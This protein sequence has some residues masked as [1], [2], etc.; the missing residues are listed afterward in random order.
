MKNLGRIKPLFI[1]L[2][3]AVGCVAAQAQLPAASSLPSKQVFSGPSLAHIS[4]QIPTREDMTAE[5]IFEQVED[6]GAV[7]ACLLLSVVA[8]RDYIETL[9]EYSLNSLANTFAYVDLHQSPCKPIIS[10]LILDTLAQAQYDE[11]SEDFWFYD[12]YAKAAT[13]LG[14]N[15]D[16][17]DS[18]LSWA[19]EQVERAAMRTNNGTEGAIWAAMVLSNMAVRHENDE[20]DIYTI[21]WPARIKFEQRLRDIIAQY[22]YLKNESADYLLPR[23]KNGGIVDKTNQTVLVQLFAQVNNFFS[24]KRAGS[25]LQV[26]W[27]TGGFN[28]MLRPQDVSSFSDATE[29]FYLHHPTPGTDGRGNWAD[30][31]NGRKH[32]ILAL[33]LQGL[34]S[35]YVTH[36]REEAAELFSS[37][38]KQ[39]IKPA[40]QGGFAHYL[41]VSL[42]MMRFGKKLLPTSAEWREEE[43]RL[44]EQLYKT[45]KRE[46]SIVP[47]M[48]TVQGGAEVGSE[49]VLF[50]GVFKVVG[51][52]VV[53]PVAKGIGKLWVK[54]MPKRTRV[55]LRRNTIERAYKLVG[56]NF[57]QS[58]HYR[59]I[60]KQIVR[61]EAE[62]AQSLT[63]ATTKAEIV[64]KRKAMYQQWVEK[65]W[66]S[67]EEMEFRIAADAEKYLGIKSPYMSGAKR[68]IN[69]IVKKELFHP[70]KKDPLAY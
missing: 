40:P 12:F 65:G 63:R 50:D 47:V 23:I 2:F 26:F 5:D 22:D 43:K 62:F 39:Y 41:F 24:Y 57:K 70:H 64:A 35:S 34:A 21:P 33:L 27:T 69:Q 42:H 30:S 8:D 48:T 61:E 52:I 3:L 49:L 45:L 6:I 20:G 38:V 7:D 67:A 53:K 17:Y 32:Q 28:D 51:K 31:P 56:K 37:F 19:F 55:A 11:M 54:Y 46:Y 16:F 60:Q 36:E 14:Y 1:A 9:D 25:Q 10:R 58:K 44:Q 4:M 18:L 59:W 15:L 13:C 29:G 66:I 68:K